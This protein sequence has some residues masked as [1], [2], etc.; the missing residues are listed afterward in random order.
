MVLG[1]RPL[2]NVDVSHK[3]FPKRYNSLIDLLRHMERELSERRPFPIDLDR[4]LNENV[5]GRLVAHLSG[6]E[7][8]YRPNEANMRIQKFVSLGEVPA[9][10]MFTMRRGD[11][12]E[13]KSVQQYFNEINRVIRYPNLQCIRLGSRDNPSA[14]PMEFCSISDNQVSRI[15]EFE[16]RA[17]LSKKSFSLFRSS[18]KNAPT[19]KPGK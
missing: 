18:T 8:C 11:V 5:C 1:E 7:I 4:P 17:R 6:L 10:E 2:L 19:I 12:T 14:V 13:R 15:V 16:S 3:A 9:R